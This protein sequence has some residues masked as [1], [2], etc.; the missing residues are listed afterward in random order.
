[1]VSPVDFLETVTVDMGVDLCGGNV[2]V[3]EHHLQGPQVCATGQKVRGKGVAEH[4]RTDCFADACSYGGL[5]NDLPET[6]SAHCRTTIRTKQYGVGFPLQEHWS[7]ILKVVADHFS[8]C[9]GKRDDS[10]LV[11]LA[12]DTYMATA[13]VAAV[14]REV[15][16]FGYP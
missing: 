11:P 8:G 3:P 1:M 4:M 6:V 13:Q 9:G 16:Q 14:E 2:G 12:E 7:S 5:P 15:N 10:F